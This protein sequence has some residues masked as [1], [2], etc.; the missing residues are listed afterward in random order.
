MD[1][2]RKIINEIIDTASK[3]KSQF[4]GGEDEKCNLIL[5]LAKSLNCKNADDEDENEESEDEEVENSGKKNKKN[6]KNSRFAFANYYQK[7]NEVYNTS[8]G[9]SKENIYLSRAEKLSA[10]EKYFKKGEK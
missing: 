2:K 4:D 3:P 5:E 8:G 9:V 7:M 6:V 1:E 10:A